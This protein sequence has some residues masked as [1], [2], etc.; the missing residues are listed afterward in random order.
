MI[1]YDLN[2]LLQEPEPILLTRV[3]WGETRNRP[4]ASSQGVAAVFLVRAASD[5]GGYGRTLRTQLLTPY[6][7]HALNLTVV[8]VANPSYTP[9]EGEPENHAVT[10]NPTLETGGPE[11]LTAIYEMALPMYNAMLQ[12]DYSLLP[13]GYTGPD[14]PDTFGGDGRSNTFEHKGGGIWPWPGMQRAVTT[15]RLPRGKQAWMEGF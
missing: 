5:Y 1:A 12:G 9:S 2:D 14:A 7:S 3:V 13:A 8:V 11:N 15:P 10:M 6:Q 4:E